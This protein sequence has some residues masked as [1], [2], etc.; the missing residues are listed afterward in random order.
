MNTRKLFSA[1]LVSAVFLLAFTFALPVSTFAQGKYVNKYSKRDVNKIISNLEQSSDSFRRDF[2]R[3]LDESS[4]NGTREED[5]LNDIV[6]DYENSLDNLRRNF[7]DTDRWWDNRADVQDLMRDARPV[8]AMMNNLPFARKLERQW[9]NMRR[10]IN[11]LAD[12]YDLAELGNDNNGGGSNIPDWAIGTFSAR[13]PQNGGNITLTINEKGNVTINMDG[14]VSYATVSGNTLLN[15][16]IESRL[17]RLDNGF[18]TTRND[19]GERIDYYRTAGGNVGGNIPDWAIGTF[20]ARNPQN[21]GNITLTINEKGSVTINMDGNVSYA[22]ISG[23][24]LFNNGIES[25][26]T[27]LNNGIRTIRNDNGERIDYFKGGFGENNGGGGNVP[28]WALGNFSAR[29]PQTG[30]N[31]LLTIN[32]NG[33]VTIN[34][35]GNISYATMNGSTL[36]NNGIESKVTRIRN[37]IRT[38]RND[39]GERIDYFKQ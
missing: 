28:S 26:V 32:A 24:T 25:R 37:G 31:I 36:F 33:N 16:G 2:D 20:S 17:S 15:N 12:T 34:M 27:R 5:R 1:A 39:N 6:R 7:N 38:T 11:K 18:R 30:G 8:N 22:T 35:D 29:N 13:N 10:D 4:L 19:N 3:Y 9:R 14:N 21:G 23:T